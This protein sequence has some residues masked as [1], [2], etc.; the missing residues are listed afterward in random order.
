VP[1]GLRVEQSVM[2]DK[3]GLPDV[4]PNAKPED[5]LRPPAAQNQSKLDEETSTVPAEK[6]QPLVAPAKPALNAMEQVRFTEEQQA[7][8][9]LADKSIAQVDL[10]AN[11]DAILQAVLGAETYEQVF[12]HLLELYPQLDMSGLREMM[13]RAMMAAEL[14]GLQVGGNDADA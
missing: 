2:C 6:Q 4:D 7:L 1:L 8:E 3:L 13:E 12:D 14:H 11:E 9:E 5:L 10:R